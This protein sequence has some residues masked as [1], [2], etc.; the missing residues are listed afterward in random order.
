MSQNKIGLKE[1]KPN[2]L[3]IEELRKHA[4]NECLSDEQLESQSNSLLDLSL[5]LFNLFQSQNERT[6]SSTLLLNSILESYSHEIPVAA[7]SLP[8]EKAQSP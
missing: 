5:I 4:G 7:I 8:I 3:S 2:K 6:D 1:H